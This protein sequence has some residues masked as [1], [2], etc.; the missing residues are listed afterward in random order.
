LMNEL[1]RLAFGTPFFS[2]VY[3]PPSAEQC[4]DLKDANLIWHGRLSSGRY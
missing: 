3:E 1:S 2:L 4:R